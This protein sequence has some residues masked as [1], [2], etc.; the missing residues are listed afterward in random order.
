[1]RRRLATH[2]ESRDRIE[3][4]ALSPRIATPSAFAL[5]PSVSLRHTKQPAWSPRTRL[6]GFCFPGCN[7]PLLRYG[8]GGRHVL[9]DSRPH[10]RPVPPSPMAL[11][12]VCARNYCPEP[13]EE[14]PLAFWARG[15]VHANAGASGPVRC[16]SVSWTQMSHRIIASSV[17]RVQCPAST[18]AVL[19]VQ[20]P[21]GHSSFWRARPRR[22]RT[23]RRSTLGS[24]GSPWSRGP[25]IDT[26]ASGG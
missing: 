8:D 7:P 26:G 25:S 3:G 4:S 23:L 21:D 16:G 22:R 6:G 9:R 1:M 24:Q 18:A 2:L 19:G 20:L 14:L 11:G 17:R 15:A 13:K 5:D 10:V 12:V